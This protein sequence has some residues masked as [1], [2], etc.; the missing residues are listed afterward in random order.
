MSQ[1]IQKEPFKTM[2]E[3]LKQLDKAFENKIRLAIMSVLKGTKSIDFNKLKDMLGTT[4][5]NLSS[6]IMVLEEK[7]YIVVKKQFIKKKSNTSYLATEKGKVAFAKHIES[8]DLIV[9]GKY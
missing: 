6:N 9:K 1:D 5:G 2:K 4:D 3:L 7:E 8:L